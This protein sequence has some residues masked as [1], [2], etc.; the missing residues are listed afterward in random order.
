VANPE[1]KRPILQVNSLQKKFP[2][3]RAFGKW[4]GAKSY[5][6]AVRDVSFQLYEGETYGLVGES[7][8]GKSTTGRTILGLTPANSGQVIYQD[9]DLVKL[10]GNEWRRFR[11][12]IQLVFQD[13]FSSLNPR[14]RIGHIL[15][16]PLIIHKMGDLAERREQVYRILKTV[17]LLPEHYFR[18]PHEFSGGQRQRLGL[19]RALIMNPKILICDEP[20]SALDVSTQ[21]QILNMLKQLQQEFKLTLLFI[22]HDISVVRYISD[23]IGI[24]YLGTI[25]E[26]APTEEIFQEPLHPYTKALFSAVPDFTQ[27]RLKERIILKGEI[28]SPLSPPSGC[29]FHTRC[30]FAT[31][32]CKEEAPSFREL[33]ANH[34]VACHYAEVQS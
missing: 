10:S 31:D 17:G 25:V 30:P 34:R 9:Q 12:D 22:T 19:A 33:K 6:N 1:M 3:Y 5:V 24:M 13:P 32:K 8:S 28:P 15:E 7:G 11:K 2:V 27:N 21:S 16:E 23:R 4:F 18:Y 26:E 20:V 29:V 14:K